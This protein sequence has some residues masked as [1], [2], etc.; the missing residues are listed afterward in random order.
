MGVWPT[1]GCHAASQKPLRA[2]Q[3]GTWKRQKSAS[4]EAL[5]RRACDGRGKGH[6]SRNLGEQAVMSRVTPVLWL[7]PQH[8]KKAQ[9]E[10]P[11]YVSLNMN[12]WSRVR[13]PP[14]NHHALWSRWFKVMVWIIYTEQKE[15][16]KMYV[17]VYTHSHTH[18][19][20]PSVNI[21]SSFSR[22]WGILSWWLDGGKK[23]KTRREG[24]GGQK[25]RW[26]CSQP[27]APGN[28]IR[29]Q[30]WDYC[31]F[32]FAAICKWLDLAAK[33]VVIEFWEIPVTKCNIFVTI[34]SAIPDCFS[35]LVKLLSESSICHLL[36][37]SKWLLLCNFCVCKK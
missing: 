12:R 14:L 1:V 16:T 31:T 19:L 13:A 26:V 2:W 18:T 7:K 34:L 23:T 30:K 17:S 9:S 25:S 35:I 32:Y 5:I 15:I 6:A 8:P 4:R 28:P 21:W 29:Q 22:F 37:D 11:R 36:S 10:N 3:S 33:H 24:N 27:S 20:T